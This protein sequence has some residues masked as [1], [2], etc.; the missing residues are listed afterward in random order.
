MPVYNGGK[1][2]KKAIESILGQ[3]L[4]DFEFL[5]I[6]D[7]STDDSCDIISS[8]KDSR[9][10]LI[11]NSKNIG[12]MAT[13]NTGLPLSN[14]QYIA[15]LDQD[16]ISLKNR[17]EKESNVLDIHN[18]AGLVYSDTFI[19]DKTGRT[20]E[21]TLFQNTKPPSN[22]SMNIFLKRNFIPGNTVMMRKSA[23]DKIGSFDPAFAI[24]AEYDLFLRLAK[25]HKILKINE[26]LAKYRVHDTNSS[27]SVKKGTECVIRVLKNFTQRTQNKTLKKTAEKAISYHLSNISIVHLAENDRVLC[28]KKTAEALKLNPL[29]LKALAAAFMSIFAPKAALSNLKK[30][31]KGFFEF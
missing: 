13:L 12:Q 10:R 15:R 3:S 16:D 29:N 25:D 9:V 5:I 26:P 17:L 1:Y 22:F 28:R 21:K 27:K 6:D 11:R 8:Y 14:G 4:K 24:A 19:I 23:V 2:L 20:R 30:F 31:R 18:D 7:K